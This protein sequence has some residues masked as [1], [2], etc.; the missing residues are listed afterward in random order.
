MN[1]NKLKAN[2]LIQCVYITYVVDEHKMEICL[3]G[4][5]LI[6]RNNYLTICLF[7]FVTRGQ[8]SLSCNRSFKIQTHQECDLK[9]FI[10]IKERK[11]T[12]FSFQLPLQYMY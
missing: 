9:E 1:G 4:K 5:K 10:S 8:S 11:I 2:L 7:E 12:Y 3:R 6:T